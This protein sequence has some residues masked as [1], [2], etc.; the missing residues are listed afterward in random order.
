MKPARPV[1]RFATPEHGIA[2]ENAGFRQ[3]SWRLGASHPAGD[4]FLS[5]L[6]EVLE[7]DDVCSVSGPVSGGKMEI[8]NRSH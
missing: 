4:Q 6:Q 5:L 1:R 8:F 3:Q 2:Q 7:A